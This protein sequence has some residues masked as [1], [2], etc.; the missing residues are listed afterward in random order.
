MASSPSL[1]HQ[2][3]L[4]TYSW[5]FVMMFAVKTRTFGKKGKKAHLSKNLC[6]SSLSIFIICH[7][8]MVKLD[9]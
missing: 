2:C 1:D 3:A 9:N 8:D 5:R 6:S 7:Q 4:F